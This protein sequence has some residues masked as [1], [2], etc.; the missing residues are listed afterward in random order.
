VFVCG[1]DGIVRRV[2]TAAQKLS[3]LSFADLIGRRLEDFPRCQPWIGA[4]EM[5]ARA[6]GGEAVS[7]QVREPLSNRTWELAA[8]PFHDGPIGSL[9][10]FVARDLTDLL[11]LQE[12]LRRTEVMS[13]LGAL[14]A[15]VAHEVRNPLF[16][17]SATIDAFEGR[18]LD[19]ALFDDYTARLRVEL[20]RLKE[21]MADLLEY[22]RP[23]D[24]ELRRGTVRTSIENALR[25]TAALAASLEVTVDASMHGA[26]AEAMI[27]E[28]RLPTAF[29]NLLDNAIRHSARGG[30][31]ELR[32]ERRNDVVEIT[33]RDR[34]TGFDD[35]D[36][37]HLFEPFFTRRRG[38]TGLGLSIVHRTIE[39]HGGSI[40]AEN[41]PDGGARM[42]VRL[43]LAERAR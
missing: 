33:V 17:I 43:P 40:V 22:G 32:V 29:R 41:H 16:A 24:P 34:G 6:A 38:G 7:T 3:G 1:S 25:S 42:R 21:L 2:N 14:V 5:L 31:V 8:M 39:Q 18:A 9:V 11:E 12:S 35:A 26:D 4:A 20:V 36:L 19:Q 13:T 10:I 23:A 28:R 37:P 27:D 15:G 30:H